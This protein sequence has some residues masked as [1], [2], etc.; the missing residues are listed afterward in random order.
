MKNS[1]RAEKFRQLVQNKYQIYNSLF[2]SLPYDKMSN[3][4]MLLPFL[5]EDSKEGYLSGKTP[6]EIVT[7]FF[8]DH[9]EIDSEEKRIDLL[10][11]IIQYIE[12][13]VVLF[14]SIEDAAFSSLHEI[15]DSGT[16]TQFEQVADERGKRKEVIEK[17]KNFAVKV[18]FT[19]HPTQFY[20]NNV[21]RILHA[22]RT[23]I[24]EDSVTKI[25]E[26]LQLEQVRKILELFLFISSFI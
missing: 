1:Q 6:V 20:S 21:Q 15:T 3:I 5:Q 25:D 12:R 10:F 17:L 16:I 22:L 9:T 23:A 24:K 19:A 18:V 8:D 13:Q 4:G 7:E 2:M 26:L 14:D 11:R